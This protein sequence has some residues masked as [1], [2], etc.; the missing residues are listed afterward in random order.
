M[1]TESAKCSLRNE[2]MGAPDLVSPSMQFKILLQIQSASTKY[3]VDELQRPR[4]D[5]K[6]AFGFVVR[7]CP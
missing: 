5:Y 2:N 7:I 3:C 1:C 6:V 4:P